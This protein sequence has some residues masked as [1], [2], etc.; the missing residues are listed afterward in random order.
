MEHH[1]NCASKWLALCVFFFFKFNIDLHPF[2]IKAC[3]NLK[4]FFTHMFN[5]W[6]GFLVALTCQRFP[7]CGAPIKEE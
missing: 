2:A 5:L 4:I 6:L 7:E 1:A 3:R